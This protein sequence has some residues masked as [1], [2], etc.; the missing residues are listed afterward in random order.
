M[1]PNAG[2]SLS[3][4]QRVLGSFVIPCFREADTVDRTLVELDA[5]ARRRADV[6]WEMILV[7][8]GSDDDT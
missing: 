2:E 3:Q 6:D 5:L 4:S 1:V 8:D 7:D